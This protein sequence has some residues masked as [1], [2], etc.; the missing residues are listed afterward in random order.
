LENRAGNQPTVSYILV[1]NLGGITTM[2]DNIIKFRQDTALDQKAFFLD[3]RENESSKS[4]GEF[5]DGIPK[6]FFGFSK[7]ENWYS[8]FGRLAELQ[9]TE[10][11][12]II[13]ND[14]YEMI[15]LSYFNVRK[16]VIQVIH[17]GYNAKLAV[18]YGDVVDAFVCH[19]VFYYEVLRQLFPDR[20]DDIYHIPYGVPIL[21]KSREAADPAAPLKLVFFGRHH[22]M[23]GVF[24]LFEIEKILREKNIKTDWLILGRGPETEKMKQQWDG[25]QNVRFVT[26]DTNAEVLQIISQRDILVFPTKFEGFPVALVEAMSVGLVPVATDLPGGLRE[27]VK[28]DVNGFLCI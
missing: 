14:V 16:K 28:N 5:G 20:R 8:V 26:P 10:D 1:N 7:K 27:L 23:K 3:I 15:M 17:D 24:D 21:G 22:P 2:L 6:I 18:Q 9:E 13:A 12:V 11:G 25:S 19:T 4:I